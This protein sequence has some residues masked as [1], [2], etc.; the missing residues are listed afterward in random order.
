[1]R[2]IESAAVLGAGTMGASIAAHLA[3]VG[4]P[5]LV[6]DIVP[7]DLS[8]EEKKSPALRNKLAVKGVENLKKM[9][10]SPLYLKDDVSLLT[11][12][13]LDDDLEK[14]SGV[15]WVIEVVA[16]N[17]AIKKSLYERVEKYWKPGMIV[18]TNTSG[19]SVN[20]MVSHCSPEFRKAFLGTHFFN[21]P[22]YMKLLEIIPGEDTDPA[23]VEFMKDFGDRVLGKGVVPAKDT[24]NF[25]G[26]RIGVYGLLATARAMQEEGLTIEEVDAVT[27]PAMGRP[28]S[29][30]FRTLDMVGLDIF[31]HVAQNVGEKVTE[32]WEVEAFKI[33][34]FLEEM[35][36]Q[37]WLGE[38]TGQ[39]F[40]KKEKSGG[41]KRI[42]TLDLEKLEYRDKAKARFASLEATKNASSVPERI[43]VLLKADDK[44]GKF[45]WK[46]L[47]DM[48]TYAALKAEEIADDIVS[49]DRAMR[50]GFNWELGPFENWDAVGVKEVVER[51]E[52]EGG[53][54]PPMVKEMLAAG[55]TSFY[56]KDAGKTFYYDFKTKQ[57]QELPAPFGTIYLPDFKEQGRIIKSN[58]GASLIDIGDGVVCLEIHS[59]R[60]ALGPDVL[61]MIYKSADEVEKN[62][63]GMVIASQAKNFCVGANLMMVLMEAQAEEWDELHLAVRQFQQSLMRLKY[64]GRPVVAAPH[65]MALGGGYEVLAHSDR[66]LAAAETYMGLVELGVGVI[67][68]GGGTKEMVIRSVENVMDNEAVD[69]TPLIVASFMNVAQAKV[70]TSAKEAK[71]LGY[72]RPQDGF[73]T[74][75]DR[76]I[77]DAKQAVLGMATAGYKPPVERKIRVIGETGFAHIQAGIFNMKEGR[78]IS[79]YDAYLAEKLAY[80]MTGGNVPAN[81]WVTEQYLLD[82]EREAFVHL[83]MQP[84]TQQRM[85]HL[86]KTGKPLRN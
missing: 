63:E 4:I 39:G 22:R 33:P 31:L 40:Y 14:I 27:G 15:D 52:K 56:K 3:N 58:T 30:T 80:I 81:T 10:P 36:K 78:Q 51:I 59:Q 83:C 69:L 66:I 24:P 12:G 32:D 75:Q 1:M 8:E 49:V 86:L 68:A 37:R 29:A 23:L 16:E 60:Q 7:P 21:P 62:W 17:M 26:N 85:G 20:E 48:M 46:A 61:S 9:K 65:G 43:Q 82:L 50:W 73:V 18:S 6:L 28:K 57:Y 55:I 74:N 76:L 47:R 45:A 44:G 35:Y 11:P 67:P 34:S 71:K 72:M 5:C 2:K 77:F 42:L 25:I 54:V 38:K 13:N 84:K 19:L 70:G 53:T 64:C 41:E 79:E